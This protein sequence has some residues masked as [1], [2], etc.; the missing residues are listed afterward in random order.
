MRCPVF[1]GWEEGDSLAQ[2]APQIYDALSVPKTLVRFL[3]AEGAGDHCAMM[4][5]SLFHQRMF[6]WLDD[7]KAGARKGTG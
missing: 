7:V 2:T 4:A 1:L 5:R 6:D 3:N